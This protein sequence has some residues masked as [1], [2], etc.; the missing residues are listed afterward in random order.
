MLYRRAVSTEFC[1]GA[2]LKPVLLCHVGSRVSGTPETEAIHHNIVREGVSLNRRPRVLMS[3]RTP[4]RGVGR[5]IGF[6]PMI[7]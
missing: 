2:L 7:N 6:Q 4:L 3:A 1:R 5:G